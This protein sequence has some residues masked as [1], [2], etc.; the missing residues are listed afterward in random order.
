MLFI[1]II[2]LIGLYGI[3]VLFGKD[4]IFLDNLENNKINYY[5]LK[6]K[7]ISNLI[8]SLSI[9]VALGVILAVDIIFSMTRY[10][11]R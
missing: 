4:Y 9:Y 2:N 3:F 1:M 8:L 7:V 10:I 11:E 5:F 6:K